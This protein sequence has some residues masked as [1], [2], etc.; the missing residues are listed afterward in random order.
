[1]EQ[2]QQQNMTTEQ[3]RAELCD[4]LR[5]YMFEHMD[6]LDYMKDWRGSQIVC[7]V[8]H[9]IKDK[10]LDDIFVIYPTNNERF[11]SSDFD[12]F[13]NTNEWLYNEYVW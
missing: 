3:D 11:T 4:K 9:Y 5:E 6:D 10:L 1:M 12:D 7:N 2:Q 13:Y 8:E